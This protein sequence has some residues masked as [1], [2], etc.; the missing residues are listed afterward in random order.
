MSKELEALE[1]I[2][3]IAKDEWNTG[4]GTRECLDEYYSTLVKALDELEN[5]KHNYE[6]L[7]EFYDNSVAY[8][9]KIQS[10]LNELN[11]DVA[12]YFELYEQAREKW[13]NGLDDKEANE[14]T[15]LHLKLMKVGKEE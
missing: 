8:G 5:A 4:T 11:H 3:Y 15:K 10:E 13:G 12:R 9:L 14:Y 7:K 6:A 1:F 2:Y